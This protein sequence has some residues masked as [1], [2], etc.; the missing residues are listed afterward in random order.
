L[1]WRG[2]AEQEALQGKEV[3]MSRKHCWGGGWSRAESTALE[4]SNRA[5]S[6]AGEG[7]GDEQEALLRRVAEQE[8]LLGRGAEQEAL[9]RR[10]SEQEALL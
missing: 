4:G 2:A 5:G 3:E 8:A 1:L 9:L 7:G 10:G 6:T